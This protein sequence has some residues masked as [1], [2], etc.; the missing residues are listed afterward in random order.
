MLDAIIILICIVWAFMTNEPLWMIAASLIS[1]ACGV[2][3]KIKRD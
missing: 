1:L 2:T 3:I